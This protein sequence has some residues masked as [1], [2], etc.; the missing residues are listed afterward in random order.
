MALPRHAFVDLPE[1][2][3]H[4]QTEGEGEPLLLLHQTARSSDEY[5][6][7]IPVLAQHYQVIAVDTLGYGNSAK[8]PHRY[9]I[10][11]YALSMI[12]F[13]NQLGIEQTNV[14]GHHTGACI[15]VEL[16]SKY[17]NR[18]RKCILSGCPCFKQPEDGEKWMN[19]PKYQPIQP[20]A[21]GTHLRRIWQM[22]M[23]RFP[24]TALD[25]AMAYVLDFLKAGERG[26]EGHWAAFVYD[27][28][29]Q[30]PLIK[31]PTLLL[32]GDK[33][34]FYADVEILKNIIPD[35]QTKIIAGGTNHVIPLKPKEWSANV[36][37]FLGT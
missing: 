15:A 19:D 35:S 3:V 30:L 27:V 22:A 7:V 28:R 9:Y 29:A 10:P 16:A 21:D 25:L 34:F 11:D 2:Q 4:Y 18:I 24:E 36:L 20:T 1:G 5:A 6:Q 13:L 8:P 17:P 37:A 33:D 23:E 12:R 14:A 32:C 31:S 26:E